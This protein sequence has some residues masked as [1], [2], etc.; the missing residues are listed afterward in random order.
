MIANGD[1]PSERNEQD[2]MREQH[3]GEKYLDRVLRDGVFE[4]WTN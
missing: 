2:T 1:G 4:Q 3:W